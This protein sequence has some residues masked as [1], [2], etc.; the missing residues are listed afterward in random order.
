MDLHEV[1]DLLV[2][3]GGINGAGIARDAAGRG[4]SVT[5]V[6]QDD[7][8]SHT[9]SAS[10]KLI[11]G[12]LRY[13]EYYE[14]HLV[15]EALMERERLLRCAPAHRLA[16]AL[17]AALHAGAAGRP[18]CCASGCSSTTISAAGR[19]CRR[20]RAVRLPNPLGVALRPDVNRGFAYSDC[21]V[22]GQPAGRAERAR[23]GRARRAT[24]HTRTRLLAAERRDG[25][26]HATVERP[27]L[28]RAAGTRARA[29]W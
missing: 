24:S 29:S 14:F 2:I 6:E 10:T 21:W 16:A 23:C 28:R 18:G 5:L 12:G 9:S 15:R 4:F 20:R 7:L 11:H 19:R 13:L 22:R 1:C 3:G 27:G 17:R 8:A 26:W 25:L